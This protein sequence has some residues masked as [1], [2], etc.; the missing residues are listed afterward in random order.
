[1]NPESSG[2][3]AGVRTI[4][5]W[6]VNGLRQ[7]HTMNEF[8]PIFQ[9]IPDI[10][11][12]QETKTQQEKIP[13]EIRD[14]PGYYKYCAPAVRGSF[15]EVMLFTREQPVSIRYGFDSNPVPESESRVMIADFGRFILVNIYFPLGMVPV[16]TLEQKLAFYD[17]F[18]VLAENLNNAGRPVIICGD[19]SIAHT[20]TDVQVIKRRTALRVGTTRVE[21]EKIHAL[22]CLGY[23]DVFR[24]IHREKRI[25]TWWPN[26]FK[27]TDR[28]R[29]YRLD[30]F[31]A[32]ERAATSIVDTEILDRVEGSDHCPVVL[33]MRR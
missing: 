11:C 28:L 2:E 27:N 12:I 24:M 31:F 33:R 3:T 19:F 5:T 13:R 9:E 32:N 29:G 16:G 20:D 21:Q 15:T 7:R 1:M 26:G 25:Y 23:R 14:L 6:N 22:V 30:Y 17:A 4:L 8:L 10:V 18:L